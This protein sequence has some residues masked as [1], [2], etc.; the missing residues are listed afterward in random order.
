M[1]PA[2]PAA[3][4]TCDSRVR[5]GIDVPGAY[6]TAGFSDLLLGKSY[7]ALDSYAKAVQLSRAG[8]HVAVALDSLR[9]IE[10]VA[11][12]LEGYAWVVRLLQLGLAATRR[13][14]KAALAA[15]QADFKARKGDTVYRPYVPAGPPPLPKD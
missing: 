10:S 2:A 12:G 5:A 3:V 14:R 9:R 1:S 8:R 6:F 13:P 11:G 15:V 7:E 4:R